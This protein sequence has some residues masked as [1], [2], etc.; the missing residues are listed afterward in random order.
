MK[1]SE[2][3]K[4]I[5]RVDAYEKVT[6]KA[7]FSADLF[8]PNMLYGKVLRSKYPHARIVKINIEKALACP[9]VEAIIRAEDIPNNEFGV[10]VQNQQVLARQE[11]LYIG[12]GIAV[13]AAETKEAD[14][15]A[16][17]LIDVEYKELPGIFDPEEAEKKDAP[18]IHSELK[19]NQ[20][21][22]HRLRKGDTEKGFAQAEVILEREYTTQFVEHGYIEPESLVAVP[23]EHNTLVTIYG[24]I[25]NPFSCR[26]AVA[27]VLKVPLNK[28]RIIQNH[29]GGSF[30]G[31]DEVMSSMA[32][33]AAILAL[34]T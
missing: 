9:G 18:L 7:K 4:S 29:M 5:K 33:R 10:I 28:V 32:A 1:F 17:E 30:G 16:L 34:K 3:N 24:S 6:G 12:D 25:Q 11:A 19:N 2:V 13:V 27:S 8:F 20:V 31:K 26:N 15:K 14:A 22:H 21:V 23:Y